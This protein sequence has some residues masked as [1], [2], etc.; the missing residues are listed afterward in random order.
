MTDDRRI[1]VLGRLET[2][3]QPDPTVAAE[4]LASL[5]P[6]VHSA[7]RYDASVAGRVHRGLTVRTRGLSHAAAGPGALRIAIALVMLLVVTLVAML[8]AGSRPAPAP[9]PFGFDGQ[10]LWTTDGPPI[11]VGAGRA[12][13]VSADGAYAAIVGDAG[14]FP[15]DSIVVTFVASGKATQVA[16]APAPQRPV[17][18]SRDALAWTFG[19]ENDILDPGV[20]I[21]AAGG[22]TPVTWRVP[23]GAVALETAWSPDGRTLAIVTDAITCDQHSGLYLFDVPTGTVR[24]IPLGG[25]TTWFHDL[26]WSP[27]GRW[28]AGGIGPNGTCGD[29]GLNSAL[30]TLDVATGAISRLTASDDTDLWSGGLWTPD[31]AW[32]VLSDPHGSTPSDA[33]VAIHPDGTGERTLGHTGAPDASVSSVSPDGRWIVLTGRTPGIERLYSPDPSLSPTAGGVTGGTNSLYAMALADG[34]TRVLADGVW[35]AGTPA[36]SPD[37]IYVVFERAAITQGG[38]GVPDS[39]ATWV[40]RPDGSGL[41]AVVAGLAPGASGP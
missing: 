15:R 27:D 2:T 11:A 13:A 38:H 24:S 37:G 4:L 30:A 39:L 28:I 18:S 25:G 5:L 14:R 40:V 41:A 9:R 36:W 1:A 7:R 12:D 20:Q 6:N 26:R 16:T 8:A 29:A 10:T 35:F 31:S 17:W 21:L 34:T 22:S 23:G 3:A 19:Y 32:L 33:V